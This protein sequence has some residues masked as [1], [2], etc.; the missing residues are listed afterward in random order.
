MSPS[1]RLS[2][3][4]ISA[5]LVVSLLMTPSLN[6]QD[7]GGENEVKIL[8]PLRRIVETGKTQAD[9]LLDRWNGDGMIGAPCMFRGTS[10][11]GPRRT[12]FGSTT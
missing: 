3:T 1:Y 4:V 2:L 9:L 11:N 12:S 10:S 5:T 8:E 7:E 6:A